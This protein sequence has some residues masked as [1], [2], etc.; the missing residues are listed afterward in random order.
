[1]AKPSEIRTGGDR[2]DRGENPFTHSGTGMDS[3]KLAFGINQWAAA[4]AGTGGKVGFKDRAARAERRD[5]LNVTSERRHVEKRVVFGD[6]FSFRCADLQGDG[7]VAPGA[8][9]LRPGENVCKLGVGHMEQCEVQT[10]ACFRRTGQFSNDPGGRSVHLGAVVED[11][12]KLRDF[13]DVS[14]GEKVAVGLDSDGQGGSERG[15]GWA[16]DCDGHAIGFDAGC[17]GWETIE[18]NR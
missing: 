12:S 3:E 10:V 6:K 17:F 13:G 9:D 18:N 5:F 11:Q 1:M 4:V 8:A 14:G 7:I 16:V 2:G 15:I